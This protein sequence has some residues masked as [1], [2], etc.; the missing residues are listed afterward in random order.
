MYDILI[1]VISF[2]EE[3]VDILA[4]HFFDAKKITMV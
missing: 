4:I 2:V 1:F 3:R